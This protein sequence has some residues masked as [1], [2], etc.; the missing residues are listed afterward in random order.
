MKK[1]QEIE[2]L[3]QLLLGCMT[4]RGSDFLVSSEVGDHTEISLSRCLYLMRGTLYKAMERFR[5]LAHV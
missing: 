1:E 3:K 4:S 5:A 2:R